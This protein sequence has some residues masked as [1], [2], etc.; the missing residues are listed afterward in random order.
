MVS[1]VSRVSSG[2]GGR[3]AGEGGAEL[4]RVC[5]IVF[6]KLGGLLFYLS[7]ECLK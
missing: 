4:H 6:L 1:M 5:D 2:R 3:W 7:S